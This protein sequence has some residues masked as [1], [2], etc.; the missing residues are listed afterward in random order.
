QAS[1]WQLTIRRYGAAHATKGLLR[2]ST[3]VIRER[4]RVAVPFPNR[5]GTINAQTPGD[6]CESVSDQSN[7]NM[8]ALEKLLL[9]PFSRCHA[10]KL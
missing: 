5:A 3:G 7:R 10:W 1:F 4:N 8:I 2:Q 9:P 6:V